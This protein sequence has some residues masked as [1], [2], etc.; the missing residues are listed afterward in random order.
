MV[1][2]MPAVPPMDSRQ[3]SIAAKAGT[4]RP[5]RT[6]EDTGPSLAVDG[7]R[8]VPGVYAASTALSANGRHWAP[9]G[10]EQSDATGRLR[11]HRRGTGAPYDAI[12]GPDA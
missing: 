11:R 6:S 1:A 9:V 3:A 2:D 8:I 12:G 5:R 4:S 10:R 7:R